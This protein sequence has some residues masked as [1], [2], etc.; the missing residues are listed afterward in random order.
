MSPEITHA[1]TPYRQAASSAAEGASAG[2]PVCVHASRMMLTF[3]R[4]GNG[5]Q[6]FV[7]LSDITSLQSPRQ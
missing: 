5:V 3:G 1:D 6:T 7:V 2:V 4:S